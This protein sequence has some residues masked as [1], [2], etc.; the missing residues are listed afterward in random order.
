MERGEIK[1]DED[2]FCRQAEVVVESGCERELEMQ[3]DRQVGLTRV[4]K[5]KRM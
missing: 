5:I 3:L 2:G 1:M 4:E